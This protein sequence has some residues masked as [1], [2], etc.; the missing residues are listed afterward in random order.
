MAKPKAPTSQSLLSELR[1]IDND[2]RL[3]ILDWLKDPERHF[4]PQVD[5]DLVDDGVCGALIAEKLG[6]S[7]PTVSE[8]MRVLV[9]AGIVDAK[10]IKQWTFYRRNEPAIAAFTLALRKSL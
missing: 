1:A 3:Q 9:D 7:Q 8:H 10:R 2:R 5:G 4:R 6:V